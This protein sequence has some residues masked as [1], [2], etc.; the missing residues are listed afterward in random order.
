MPDQQVSRVFSKPHR[1]D[2]GYAAAVA[3]TATAM[4]ISAIIRDSLPELEF[5]RSLTPI[6]ALTFVGLCPAGIL[7]QVIQR[8]LLP[9]FPMLLCW[10]ASLVF[11]SMFVLAFYFTSGRH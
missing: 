7:I 1:I 9:S 10:L 5:C 11:A 8:R 2:C 3:F 4:V 6:L